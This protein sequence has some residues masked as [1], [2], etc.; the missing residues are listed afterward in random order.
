MLLL[1]WSNAEEHKG[2][3]IPN[4]IKYEVIL[5]NDPASSNM[6]LCQGINAYHKIN[7]E[8]FSFE[9]SLEGLKSQGNFIL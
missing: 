5:I 9:M 7:N 6:F 8:N 3:N 4:T 1:P 2:F